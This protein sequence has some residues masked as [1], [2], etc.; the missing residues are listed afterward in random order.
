MFRMIKNI[1]RTSARGFYKSFFDEMKPQNLFKKKSMPISSSLKIATTLASISIPYQCDLLHNSDKNTENKESSNASSPLISAIRKNNWETLERLL[2]EGFKLKISDMFDAFDLAYGTVT[3]LAVLELLD[4]YKALPHGLSMST[5]KLTLY[6]IGNPH[7]KR[8]D[9]ENE[10]DLDWKGC[11]GFYSPIHNF[12]QLGR[13]EDVKWLMAH[14]VLERPLFDLTFTPISNYCPTA[15]IFYIEHFRQR[16]SDILTGKTGYKISEQCEIVE[17]FIKNPTVDLDKVIY[18][19]IHSGERKNE[20]EDDMGLFFA[21][22]AVNDKVDLLE[23]KHFQQLTNIYPQAFLDALKVATVFN[24]KEFIQ[25]S[26]AT[27]PRGSDTTSLLNYAIADGNQALLTGV[28][29][30]LEAKFGQSIFN[31]ES[32]NTPFFWAVRFENI[33][34][35]HY[36]LKKN[37]NINKQNGFGDSYLHLAIRMGNLELVKTMLDNGAKL[38]IVYNSKTPLHEACRLKQWKIAELLINKDPSLTIKNEKGESPLDCIEDV[39]IKNK[40]LLANTLQQSNIDK[41]TVNN[42]LKR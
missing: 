17:L 33:S 26:I 40:L 39:A 7:I 10:A 8:S 20:R 38:D 27:L 30:T 22:A 37:I 24:K 6:S 11:P 35:V 34:A 5:L 21:W 12:S 16:I 23:N 4:K 3:E 28:G 32:Y 18:K 31:V 14:H 15:G 29:D 19:K 13:V 1:Y 9:F 25:K 2:K 42:R 41:P 36:L